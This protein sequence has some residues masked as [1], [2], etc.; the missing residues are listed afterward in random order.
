MPS[1]SICFTCEIHIKGCSVF[2]PSTSDLVLVHT[3]NW[4]FYY[5]FTGTFDVQNVTATVVKEHFIFVSCFFAHNSKARGCCV[6]STTQ[7]QRP[8][9]VIKR[10][11][12]SNIGRG[13]FGPVK[14]GIHELIIADLEKNTRQCDFSAIAMRVTVPPINIDPISKFISTI[15]YYNL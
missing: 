5:T 11:T 6:M 2:C 9:R 10:N 14:K 12:S 8:P 3:G 15:L 13:I 1:C 4:L 7:Q